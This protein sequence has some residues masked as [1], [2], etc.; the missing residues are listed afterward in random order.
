MLVLGH[1]WRGKEDS[2]NKVM[3]RAGV[4]VSDRSMCVLYYRNPTELYGHI[5]FSHD[6]VAP[7][8]P[9]LAPNCMLM[10]IK[11]QYQQQ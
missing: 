5:D 11:H 8:T 2:N 1:L 7:A 3:L 9:N 10:A 4:E 6:Q